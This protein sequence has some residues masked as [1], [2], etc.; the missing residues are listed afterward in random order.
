MDEEAVKVKFGADDKRCTRD[1]GDAADVG[2]GVLRGLVGFRCAWSVTA[3]LRI[4]CRARGG[5]T[6]MFDP[7]TIVRKFPGHKMYV[8]GNEEQGGVGRS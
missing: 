1:C 3:V 2:D 4:R 8:D 7:A 5:G 6:R